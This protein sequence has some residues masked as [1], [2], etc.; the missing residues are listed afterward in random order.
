MAELRRVTHYI[1]GKRVEGGG[2]REGDHGTK[3]VELHE[4]DLSRG[5]RGGG[6]LRVTLQTAALIGRMPHRRSRK[7]GRRPLWVNSE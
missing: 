1:D 4:R 3:A 7:R 2:G 5:A 6:P